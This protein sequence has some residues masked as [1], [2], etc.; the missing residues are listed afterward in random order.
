MRVVLV[1]RVFMVKIKIYNPKIIKFARELRKNSTPQE[2]KLW[3][4][5]KSSKFYGFK[6]RR[7]FPIDGYI[8]DLCCVKAKL[9][10]EV[11]GGQHSNPDD[12]DYDIIR[13]AEIKK[14]GYRILRIWNN[15]LNENLEGVGEKIHEMLTNP[16]PGPLPEGEGALD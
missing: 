8:V 13:D 5:L 11:D 14:S 10:I 15:Q 7:Q 4:F 16:H 1:G 2:R 3:S 6:F 9:V 12:R